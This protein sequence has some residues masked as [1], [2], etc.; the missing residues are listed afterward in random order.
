[1]GLVQSAV[2]Y[3]RKLVQVAA[4]ANA[5]MSRYQSLPPHSIMRFDLASTL[6]LV[7]FGVKPPKRPPASGCRAA[8]TLAV[9]F[10]RHAG[11]GISLASPYHP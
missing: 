11:S 5:T 6:P 3:R 10:H 7:P 9:S 4:P 2:W 1:M 8:Q